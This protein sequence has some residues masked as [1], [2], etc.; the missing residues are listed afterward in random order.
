M[1]KEET[2]HQRQRETA[3]RKSVRRWAW[4][5]GIAAFILVIWVLGAARSLSLFQGS[6][7]FLG[8]YLFVVL[9]LA[10]QLVF[11]LIPTRWIRILFAVFFVPL[12]FIVQPMLVLGIGI[13]AGEPHALQ[14][15][16][17]AEPVLT[18]IQDEIKQT[19]SV[20]TGILP[21]L[22]KVKDGSHMKY[23]WYA[24][25]N[26]DFNLSVRAATF[27]YFDPHSII[28]TYSSRYHTWSEVSPTAPRQYPEGWK[29]VRYYYDPLGNKFLQEKR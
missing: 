21:G 26:K 13:L 8:M 19:G 2:A 11:S 23:V 29:V 4:A 25:G 17:D 24:A 6:F 16:R 20:P 9:V 10:L 12:A 5:F 28:T 1:G 22:Q 15:Q 14:A 18:F 3:S 7:M 27:Y